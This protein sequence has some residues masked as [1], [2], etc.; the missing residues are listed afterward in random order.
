MRKSKFPLRFSAIMSKS[1]GFDLL[2]FSIIR[3]L[4]WGKKL[5][6]DFVFSLIVKLMKHF[7]LLKLVI[8]IVFISIDCGNETVND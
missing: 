4:T 7:L 8:L 2:L 6:N 5:I 1:T 3:L